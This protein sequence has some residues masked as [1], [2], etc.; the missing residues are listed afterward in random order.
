MTAHPSFKQL[1]LIFLGMMLVLLAGCAS[2]STAPTPMGSVRFGMASPRTI[3]YLASQ[4]RGLKVTVTSS[5]GTTYEQ[6]F[7][8]SALTGNSF[9]FQ[10]M[11]LPV[12]SYTAHLT[13]YM[14]VAQTLV[15]G[16]T[17]SNSFM[18][19]NGE[20]TTLVFPP[21]T[22]GSTPVGNWTVAPKVTLKNNYKITSYTYT[23]QQT[24]GTSVTDTS[25]RSTINWENVVCFPSGISTTS[26]TV[27]AKR[28]GS[29]KTKTAIATVSVQ[30]G[31]TVTSNVSLS[32]P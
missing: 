10:A 30:A 9:N 21:L 16:T 17:T 15:G 18:V 1:S 14:D 26:V 31:Q 4:I 29:T 32:F 2:I 11:N 28:N 27:T 7:D 24:D 5:T 22:L 19:S 25:M 8:S 12:G 23:L 20:T 13:A 6:N 3:Q